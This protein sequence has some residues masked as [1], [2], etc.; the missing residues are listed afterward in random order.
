MQ[1]DETNFMIDPEDVYEPEETIEFVAM[2]GLHECL[3]NYSEIHD[4]YDSAAQDLIDMHELSAEL[5]A[6]LR[7]E[8]I[9]ELNLG[10]HGNEYCEIV[11]ADK[12]WEKGFD[13]G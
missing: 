7:K 12:M 10:M 5:E 9:V 11:K 6:C 4:S 13:T 2:A 8:G 1:P 3:P